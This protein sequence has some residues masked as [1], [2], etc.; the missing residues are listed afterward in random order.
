MDYFN[1]DDLDSIAYIEEDT[2]NVILKFYG[3]SNKLAADLFISYAML[4]MG[5]NYQ[6][7][8]GTKSNMIH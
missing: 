7:I 6:P 5:F 4:N 3:F 2:N 8:S 1:A